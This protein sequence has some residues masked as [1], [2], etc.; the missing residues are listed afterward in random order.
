MS[1]K[2]RQFQNKQISLANWVVLILSLL[3]LKTKCN[4]TFIMHIL[5]FLAKLGS[6]HDAA[7]RKACSYV[8]NRGYI[9]DWF[10]LYQISKN[11]NMYF[12]RYECIF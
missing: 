3:Y 8:T 4:T 9:G 11:V 10:V 2:A 7:A 5:I 1:E 12:F 6:T